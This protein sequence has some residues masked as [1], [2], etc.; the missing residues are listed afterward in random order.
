MKTIARLAPAAVGLVLLIGGIHKLIYPGEATIALIAVGTAPPLARACI[1][2]LTALELYLGGML[3]LGFDMKLG[4][5]LAT[6]L[7]FTYSAFLF[8]LSTMANPPSCGCLGLNGAFAS[9]K[10]AAIFGLLRNCVLLFLLRLGMGTDRRVTSE[11]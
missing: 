10:Q 9:N 7:I 4:L 2:L 8:Y 1:T 11:L 3:I 5:R 6:G